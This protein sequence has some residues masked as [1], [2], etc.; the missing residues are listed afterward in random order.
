M[1][2]AELEAEM[3]NAFKLWQDLQETGLKAERPAA[4]ITYIG[5][6]YEGVWGNNL[7]SIDSG[8]TTFMYP[9]LAQT[10]DATAA[11]YSPVGPTKKVAPYMSDLQHP[12][13]E[14]YKI[15]ANN[16]LK[17]IKPNLPKKLFK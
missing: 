14:G 1:T 4:D 13:T 9:R 15:V 10:Y 6:L 3:W 16:V 12:N 11:T 8:Y 5:C 7:A 2:N 17:A